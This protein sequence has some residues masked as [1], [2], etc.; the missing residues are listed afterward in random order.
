ML[1]PYA[2]LPA[3]FPGLQLARLEGLLHI[4]AQGLLALLGLAALLLVPLA[5]LG[6]R[7]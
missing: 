5:Y 7:A 3:V 1:A 2:P 4:S 6:A